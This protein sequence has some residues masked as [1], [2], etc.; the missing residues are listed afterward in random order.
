MQNSQGIS[1]YKERSADLGKRFQTLII[2]N[3]NL[4][5]NAFVQNI[6]K[7]QGIKSSLKYLTFFL[8]FMLLYLLEL[9]F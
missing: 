9:L 1:L 5:I 4:A 7:Y 2:N 3:I 8:F 6:D